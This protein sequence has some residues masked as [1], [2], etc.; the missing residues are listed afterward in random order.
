MT[1]LR[2]ALTQ[3]KSSVPCKMTSRKVRNTRALDWPKL[4]GKISFWD[5]FTL[6]N[7]NESYGVLLDK[8]ISDGKLEVPEPNVALA[9]IEITK[10]EHINQL[11]RYS[12]GVLGPTFEFAREMLSVETGTSLKLNVASSERS[13]VRMA[14]FTNGKRNGR[15]KVDHLIELDDY[16]LPTLVIGLGRPGH[17]F[18][19]RHLVNGANQETVWPL[20]QLANLCFHSQ[21]RFGYILT[22]EDLVA[23]CFSTEDPKSYDSAWSVEVMPVPWTKAGQ[24]QLTTDLALWWL[25]ML[26]ISSRHNRALTSQEHMTRINDWDVHKYDDERGWVR[27]HKYSKFEEPTSEPLPPAYQPPSPSNADGVAAVFF[28]EVGINADPAFNL[29]PAGA[30]DYM[31]NFDFNI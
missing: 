7:L 8:P 2:R 16:R 22:E 14:G 24:G 9:T 26:A 19:G 30:D 1:T 4:G 31:Q 29:S 18:Q 15:L 3:A 21:T 25:C 6:E 23:C 28:A 13:S 12:D 20:R 5:D 27:R 17:S 11:I 10:P